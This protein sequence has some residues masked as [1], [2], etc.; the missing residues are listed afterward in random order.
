MSS[1]GRLQNVAPNSYPSCVVMFT[2]KR[3][4]S[5]GTVLCTAYHYR[6]R[7]LNNDLLNDGGI[8]GL[9]DD[10]CTPNTTLLV[11]RKVRKVPLYM[12]R[13]YLFQAA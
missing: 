11:D 4:Q 13:G 8:G 2:A 9:Y 12:Y 10:T 7:K 5:G 3:R 1:S 6:M